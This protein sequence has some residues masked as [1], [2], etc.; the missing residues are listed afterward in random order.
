MD[1]RTGIINHIYTQQSE[2][3]KFILLQQWINSF[4]IVL[5]NSLP[6][7]INDR[8]QVYAIR[9]HVDKWQFEFY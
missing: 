3:N 5:Q 7:R 8:Y 1:E 4:K 2:D 6:C 9:Y